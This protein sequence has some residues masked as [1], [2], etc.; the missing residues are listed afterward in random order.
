MWKGN[1]CCSGVY[2]VDCIFSHHLVCHGYAWKKSKMLPYSA[3]GLIKDNNP[4]RRCHT[5]LQFSCFSFIQK[6]TTLDR[7]SMSNLVKL[8]SFKRIQM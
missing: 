7:F 3:S 5:E 1:V 2:R 4:F 6:L 8:Q